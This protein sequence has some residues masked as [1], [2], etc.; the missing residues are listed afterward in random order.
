MEA[1]VAVTAFLAPVDCDGTAKDALVSDIGDVLQQ[2]R[3]FVRADPNVSSAED[4]ERLEG[5]AR[6]IADQLF[7]LF[8]PLAYTKTF[9]MAAASVLAIT[10]V[11]VMML[12]FLRRETVKVRTA[13]GTEIQVRTAYYRER[14]KKGSQR[15]PGLYPAL[16]VLGIWD[17]CTPSLASAVSKSV[18]MLCSMNEAQSHLA[19]EGIELDVKTIRNIAYRYAARGR[20]IQQTSAYQWGETVAGQRLVVSLD[21]GRLRVRRNKRG[22]RTRKGRRRFHTDWHEPKLLILYVVGPDGR[23]SRTWAPIIDG[24]LKGPDAI[25]ALIRSYAQQ[26][27]LSSAAKVLFIADGAPWI[28]NRIDDLITALGL[29]PSQVLMLIDFYHAAKQLSD[30]VKLRRWRPKRRT[31]WLNKHRSLLRRGKIDAVIAG[32]KQLCVGRNAGKLGT[33]LR[34]FVKNR[35]RFSYPMFARLKLPKG[36]GAMESAIRRVVNLRIKGASIYWLE[37]SAE[38]ILLLRSFYKSRRW[39]ILRRLAAYPQDCAK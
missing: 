26:I 13:R 18:A 1:A 21:G 23:P 38:A 12:S 9:A 31:R 24:T 20:T 16:S 28:W 33:H 19:D 3:D 17:R 25:F 29:R 39:N 37:E 32:L 4:L 27:E 8:K 11:P 2:A 22:K 30:A 36:S 15:R 10:L 35:H 6:Q 14:S 5:Q 34:Y 7:R